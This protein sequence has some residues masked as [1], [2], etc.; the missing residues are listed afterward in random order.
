MSAKPVDR[1][2]RLL[3]NVH[4][5]GTGWRAD[6]PN[7]HSKSRSSLAIDEADDGRILMKCFA[8][9]DTQGIL[10][11]VGLELADLFPERIKDPSPAACKA[12][13]EAFKRNGWGAALG[14]LGREAT[15]VQI[16]AHDLAD[17]RALNATDHARVLLACDRIELARDVLQ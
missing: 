1:L 15:I 2:L 12:A 17:N 6:C 13:H 8:C 14:L 9:H 5:Y 10:A 3:H 16:A 11:A 7:G 4:V